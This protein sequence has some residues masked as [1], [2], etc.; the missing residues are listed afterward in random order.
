MKVTLKTLQQTVFVVEIDEN[1]LVRKLKEKIEETRKKEFNAD[2]MKLIYSGKIWNDDMVLKNS[3]YDE[4]KFV[5]VMAVKPVTQSNPKVSE[6]STS[7]TTT[8]TSQPVANTPASTA[9]AVAAP[10]ATSQSATTQSPALAESTVVVGEDYER[11]VL[12]IMEMGYERP[13]VERALRA[14]FNNPDRA[15]EYLITGIPEDTGNDQPP[16]SQPTQQPRTTDSSRSNPLAAAAASAGGGGGAANV[17]SNPLS[18]LLEQPQFQQM[19]QAVQQNPSLLHNLM[20]QI[21]VSNP[22]L[23]QLISDNQEA[24][25]QM[26]NEPTDSPA[27]TAGAGAAA[28]AGSNVSPAAAA[29]AVA[30]LGAGSNIENLFGTAEITQQDKE[31][32]DRL[33]ALGFPEYLVVQAYFACDKNENMAAN[34]L[35]SQGIDE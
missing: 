4:S 13:A 35:L 30:G 9:P 34:F 22:Q 3:G 21:G 17:G 32:I 10:T 31:A 15:V 11:I 33:K 24:F 7:T 19:R 2:W 5:V 29:A 28:S 26:L 12:Q 8:A 20:Q 18:F 14:S 6:S 23:L 27:R 16:P 25:L 1:E